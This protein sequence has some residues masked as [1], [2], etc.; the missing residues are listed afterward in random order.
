M[1]ARNLLLAGLVLAG[2]VGIAAGLLSSDSVEQP[3][4]FDPSR[5]DDATARSVIDQVD[6]E[7]EDYWTENEIQPTGRADN[8]AI[9]RRLSLGLT[10]T[11]PSYEELKV[12]ETLPEDDQIEWW[13]SRL[14]EDRRY[15]DYV[16]E[17]LAR[18]CVG[19]EGGPFLVF[20]RRRFTTWLSD[21]LHVNRPYDEIVRELIGDTGIWTES[22]AVNFLTVTVNP[23]ADGKPDPIR[24]AGRT[25]R[26][27]L[28][29]RIDCLQ[30]HD[31]R[32]GNVSLGTSDNPRDGLQSDF[33]HFAAFYGGVDFSLFGVSDGKNLYKYKYLGADEE[34][35]IDVGPPFLT[36]L[37]PSEGSRR[38]RLAAWVTHDQNKP[39]ARAIVN[40]TWALMFGKPLVEPID[41][42][43]LYG[44]YP[45]ALET[46]AADFVENDCD[47]RHLI[48]VIAATRTFQLASR[49]EFEVH[50]KHENCWAVFPVT[51]LR[52]EQVAGSVLQAARLKTIDA[53]S[54]IFARIQRFNEQN[55][56]INR[57]GDAGE[58][59]FDERAGTITQRLLMMNGKLVKEQTQQNLVLNAAT[60]IAQ[61]APT[62]EK[63]VETAYLAVLTRR[64]SPAELAHFVARLEGVSGDKRNLELEDLYWVLINGTEFSWNH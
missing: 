41:D 48:R 35:T 33:H 47:L 49:A 30:C 21:Q 19:V 17:R 34:E 44:E 46:L 58:D 27:F 59:E 11:V 1:W 50:T 40:R 23:D 62:N 5:F 2:F 16:A 14:L 54:H 22:P 56:F 52:P 61:L 12:L 64:P 7:F 45:P 9:V 28:G 38:Q 15:A 8:L 39:F 43:P 3:V 55:E 51:R 24:L 60:H 6:R 20:R 36:E 63:A 29:M 4:D 37:L 57:Y 32:M 53:K 42:I 10:G 31:D 18:V 13:L 26:A 25:T